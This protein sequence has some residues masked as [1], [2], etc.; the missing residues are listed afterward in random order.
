MINRTPR[1]CQGY[2]IE[3][4]HRQKTHQ[5]NLYHEKLNKTREKRKKDKYII[6]DSQNIRSAAG[7]GYQ[8]KYGK[9]I[10]ITRQMNTDNNYASLLQKTWLPSIQLQL[11]QEGSTYHFV[12]AEHAKPKGNGRYNGGVGIILS[13]M[14]YR[15]WQ[16][17]DRW[18]AHF[19]LNIIAMKLK[20]RTGS[21]SH[22]AK[23]TKRVYLVSGYSP[24]NPEIEK[25]EMK[26]YLKNLQECLKQCQNRKYILI[27]GTDA[28]ISFGT[29]RDR[30]RDWP[31]TGRY[32][33]PVT[34]TYQLNAA[35]KMQG[36]IACH[37]LCLATT[38]FQSKYKHHT[39]ER[40]DK[41]KTQ[42]DHIIIKE[43]HLRSDI[44]HAFAT[45]LPLVHSDHRRIRVKLGMTIRSRRNRGQGTSTFSK[46]ADFLTS[47]NDDNGQTLSEHAK[48]KNRQQGP[49]KSHQ[50]LSS[51]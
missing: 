30:A 3:P 22:K 35:N 4:R 15:A 47:R 51:N 37:N 11:P 39:W 1:L 6:I 32:G 27:M 36:L 44:K 10:E 5:R 49:S 38:F 28:N 26:A 29:N 20:I 12:S 42:I 14:A 13:P 33:I 21:K 41:L 31:T 24:C 18:M 7:Y 19:G 8:G 23:H 17:H 43:K 34:G 50:T 48:E 9:L 2:L 25:A 45:H 16:S 40:R 46:L